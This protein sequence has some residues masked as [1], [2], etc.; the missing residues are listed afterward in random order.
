MI[1]RT[2][3]LLGMSALLAASTAAADSI[4]VTPLASSDV[5][6]IPI[7]IEPGS[8]PPGADW[9]GAIVRFH[10]LD[11]TE[12]SADSIRFYNGTSVDEPF[13]PRT[14]NAQS[15]ARAYSIWLS[16]DSSSQPPTNS[17]G[18]LTVAE[19]DLHV[20][21]IDPAADGA[22][23]MSMTAWNIWRIRGDDSTTV[24]LETSNLLYFPYTYYPPPPGGSTGPVGGCCF[25]PPGTS[26]NGAAGW[27]FNRPSSGSAAN[28]GALSSENEDSGDPMIP[29]WIHHQS[30]YSY[31]LSDLFGGGTVYATVSRTLSIG[32]EGIPEP[33]TYL[34][35]SAGLGCL[36]A[37]RWCRCRRLRTK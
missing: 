32:V 21:E 26:S 10:V 27:G 1:Q 8:N 16:D 9:V 12:V 3:T 11:A 17:M 24:H 13:G 28:L 18:R 25:G 19:V 35:L 23:D 7:D 33:A 4:T 5:I 14:S 30:P 36:A 20:N 6:S 34:A 2:F 15:Q 37:H 31:Q 29:Y 22:A